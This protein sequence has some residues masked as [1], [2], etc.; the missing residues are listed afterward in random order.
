MKKFSGITGNLSATACAIALLF[1]ASL[2]LA[3]NAAP[4]PQC[5]VK[6][7]KVLG[8]VKRRA[9]AMYTPDQLIVM[10]KSD[11]DKEEI[12]EALT[13]VNGTVSDKDLMGKFFVIKVDPKKID[14]IQKELSKDKNF[15]M[16][17]RNHIY[18]GNLSFTTTPNDPG[19]SQQA[20]LQQLD[21]PNAWALGAAGQG[22]IY[23][24]LDTGVDFFNQDLAGRFVNFGYNSATGAFNAY[25]FFGP[26]TEDNSHGTYT[27]NCACSSTN[28][29]YGF[30]SPAFLSGIEPV[31]ISPDSDSSDDILIA[32]GLQFQ[33]LNNVKVVN[34]SFNSSDPTF[35]FA[36][37][38]KDNIFKYALGTFIGTGG[39]LF[40]SAGNDGN[41]I[42]N[43]IKLPGYVVVSA[44]NKDL[45]PAS[46]TDFGPAVVFGAPG[47]GI[48]QTGFGGVPLTAD[49]TSISSPLCAGICCQ[50]LSA[51]PRL[52]P[53][54]A[55]QI[56][57]STA[58]IPSSVNGKT[59]LFY[60][61]G[62]PDSAA[63]VYFAQHSF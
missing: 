44:L 9:T 37:F 57:E 34:L 36:A 53:L 38:G 49:G 45:T 13:K 50:V 15:A 63:A 48:T 6:N 46:F 10:P 23:G 35:N 7:P 54:Q 4:T 12:D 24:S 11:S 56:M 30:A 55:V 33:I 43:G 41:L 19:F 59:A 20:D 27:T 61:F 51:N 29:G 3:A 8:L 17:E 60:G 14:Q 18:Q 40:N 52:T 5:D 22:V 28:N 58:K 62:V 31:N 32:K 1:S 21:I 16:V 2:P 42:P 47:V 25:D 39:V 26:F